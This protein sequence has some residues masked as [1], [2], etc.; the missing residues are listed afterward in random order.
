MTDSRGSFVKRAFGTISVI[1]SSTCI[2][3]MAVAAGNCAEETRLLPNGAYIS[4]GKAF[5]STRIEDWQLGYC[6]L[7]NVVIDFPPGAG[8]GRFR[9]E[10]GTHFTHNRDVWHFRMQLFTGNPSSEHDQVVLF[11]QTWDGPAMSE[12]DQPLFHPWQ[13]QFSIDPAIDLGKVYWRATSC[14]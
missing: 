3:P 4:D 12:L 2:V 11:D 8:I 5:R 9:G 7:R 1:A 14:C 6:E 10:V 13:F